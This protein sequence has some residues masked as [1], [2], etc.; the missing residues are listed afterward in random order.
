[1]NGR[2]EVG[3]WGRFVDAVCPISLN[4]KNQMIYGDANGTKDK[5]WRNSLNQRE[6]NHGNIKKYNLRLHGRKMDGRSW[7]DKKQKSCVKCHRMRKVT[8]TSKFMTPQPDLETI[9]IHILPNIWQS[10]DNQIIKM[11]N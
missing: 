8:L 10:K 9:A 1:M 7:S 6:E 5:A 2:H 11:F 4:H 3:F